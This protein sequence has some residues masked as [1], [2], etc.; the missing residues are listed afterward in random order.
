[1]K[2]GPQYS[3]QNLVMSPQLVEARQ[4]KLNLK[5]SNPIRNPNQIKDFLKG[6]GGNQNQRTAKILESPL[7]K[8]ISLSEEEW[9]KIVKNESRENLSHSILLNSLRMGIPKKLRPKIWAFLINQEKYLID[10]VIVLKAAERGLRE[11][12][13]SRR[14]LHTK[15][16]RSDR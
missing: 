10:F 5:P 4:F 6:I 7:N 11:V 13:A 16:G 1:M 3:I 9:N 8:N 15:G 12:F 14:R 2:S